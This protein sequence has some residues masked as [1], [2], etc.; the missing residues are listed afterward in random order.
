MYRFELDS[1]FQT[2]PNAERC[3][4]AARLGNTS[5]FTVLHLRPVLQSC[6]LRP[7][8]V[9]GQ[10]RCASQQPCQHLSFLQSHL[11]LLNPN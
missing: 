10:L 1:L 6:H 8:T 2:V 5:V 11:P 3:S 7:A 4:P 9:S